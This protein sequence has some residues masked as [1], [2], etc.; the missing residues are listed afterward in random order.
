M[1]YDCPDCGKGLKTKRGMESHRSQKHNW[2]RKIEFQCEDCGDVVERKRSLVN[3]FEHNFCSRECQKNWQSGHWEGENGT[4][5]KGGKKSLECSK[6]GDEF[7][8]YETHL[9]NPDGDNFCSRPCFE[10]WRSENLVGKKHHNWKG[11]YYQYYGRSW[12]DQRQK[13]IER[14]G[15][16]V[17]CG[18]S[19]SEYLKNKGRNLDVHHKVPFKEFDDY[20]EAN[21]LSNL[22]TVCSECHNEIEPRKAAQ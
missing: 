11:G 5:W 7:E 12:S 1:N 17:K 10:D 22:V 19:N 3:Q 9:R 4:N 21:A 8:R 2:S 14:D 13:A 15:E 16:C 6:C 18:A 20:R